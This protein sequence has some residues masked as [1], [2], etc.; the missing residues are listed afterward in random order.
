M[1]AT[2][3]YCTPGISQNH[4]AEIS[5]ILSVRCFSISRDCKLT[6]DLIY[7]RFSTKEIRATNQAELKV[8]LF[9][10]QAH[11]LC[12]IQIGL[13]VLASLSF[14]T[15][16]EVRMPRGTTARAHFVAINKTACS[17]RL[18]EL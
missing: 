12:D 7:S 18:S 11:L 15:R 13:K 17:T 1:R 6:K 9:V 8:T 10:I 14:V 16:A 5:L 2:G 4:K 3:S